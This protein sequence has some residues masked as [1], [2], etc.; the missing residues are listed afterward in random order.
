MLKNV[1]SRNE[2]LFL[3]LEASF[4]SEVQISILNSL[5]QI[6]SSDNLEF[7]NEGKYKLKLESNN[8]N[9]GMYFIF[10]TM[11]GQNQMLKLIV[12]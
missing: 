9:S 4:N 11:N 2:D 10:V 12:Q 1:I 8:L 3:E 6:L 7:Y 5:G